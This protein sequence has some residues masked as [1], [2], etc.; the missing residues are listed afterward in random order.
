M[1]AV[2][3]VEFVMKEGRVISSKPAGTP[4]E[5]SQSSR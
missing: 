4:A 3:R 5:S 2:R 1:S